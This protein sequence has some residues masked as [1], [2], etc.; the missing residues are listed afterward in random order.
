MKRK[1][2]AKR[3]GQIRVDQR[4]LFEISLK[5]RESERNKLKKEQ[6]EMVQMKLKQCVPDTR[7]QSEDS[8]V[9]NKTKN[10]KISYNHESFL[11]RCPMI[12]KESLKEISS[13]NES[14]LK[15]DGQTKTKKACGQS[16]VHFD[17]SAHIHQPAFLSPG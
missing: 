10:C 6:K 2:T 13:K 17:Q 8:L 16:V 4:I 9:K 12:L 14:K 1:R 7:R 11:Q 3:I 5:E 15:D